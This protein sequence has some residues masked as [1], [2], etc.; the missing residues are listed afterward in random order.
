VVKAP[1]VS[2][3][4]TAYNREAYIGDAIESVL[5]QRFADF[6]LVIVDD[7]S[8]DGTRA[9]AE[10]YAR[11]DP[12]V[13]VLRNDTN[14]GDYGNRNRA[15][16]QARAP[17]LKYHDSDDIM[18]PHCLEVMVSAMRGAPQAALGLSQGRQ[19]PGGPCPMV[20]TPGLAYEREF[21]GHGVFQCGPGGAIIRKEAFEA[22]GRF[23]NVGIQ[24]DYLLWLDLAARFP[25][26]L[27]PADLFWYREHAQQG[28]SGSRAAFDYAR[29]NGEVWRVLAGD[30]APLSGRALEL[31]RRNQTFTVAKQLWRDIKRRRFGVAAYR[32]R[33]AGLTPLD[34]CRYL[35]PPR[36]EAV[37][38]TPLGP[39]GETAMSRWLF[40]ATE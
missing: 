23:R 20:L 37:A 6:E 3:L 7:C 39:N 29:L 19:W 22:A 2:V 36:R 35:R 16:E 15:S 27:L 30:G 4:M 13:R 32:V 31:A 40:E 5:N 12:R 33:H 18:Y 38:G 9:I 1:A 10:R 21:L 11:G 8:A 26:V 14:L 24:S 34:W 17:L 25:I 28:L